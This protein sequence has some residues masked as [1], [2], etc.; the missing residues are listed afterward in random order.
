M[1]TLKSLPLFA[2]LVLFCIG[3][4]TNLSAQDI[5]PIH[6]DS[7]EETVERIIQDLETAVESGIEN[8]IDSLGAK[9]DSLINDLTESFVSDSVSDSA[10]DSNSN[11]EETEEADQ[12]TDEYSGMPFIGDFSLLGIIIWLCIL[13]IVIFLGIVVSAILIAVL[14]FLTIAGVIG[15]S[16]IVGLYKR[17]LSK[18]FSTFVVLAAAVFGAGASAIIGSIRNVLFEG[19]ELY[20]NL[21]AFMAMGAIAGIGLGFIILKL[22]NKLF[23]FLKKKY[24]QIKW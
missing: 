23:A 21:D 12:S 13:V 2:T 6:P 8:G 7:E 19:V 1:K 10:S 14:L 22:L 18:G 24:H 16:L 15:T 17:S 20:E 3:L 5:R 4:T 11:N 9:K